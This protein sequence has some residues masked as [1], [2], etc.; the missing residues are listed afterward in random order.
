MAGM[1]RAAIALAVLWGALATAGGPSPCE[2]GPDD[3]EPAAPLPYGIRDVMITDAALP[4]GWKKLP[5]GPLSADAKAVREAI[6]ASGVGRKVEIVERS[7]S[8]ADGSTVCVLFVQVGQEAAAV[9]KAASDA[10]ASPGR[11]YLELGDASRFAVVTGPDAARKAFVDT[12]TAHAVRFLVK[13]ASAP[14]SGDDAT[15]L[16]AAAAAIDPLDAPSRAIVG[17]RRHGEYRTASGTDNA[18]EADREVGRAAE[19]AIAAIP[20]LRAA[21][22]PDVRKPLE[23]ERALEVKVALG[24]ALLSLGGSDREAREVLE[25]ASVEAAA[26]PLE[27]SVAAGFHL[28]RSLARLKNPGVLACLET[29]LSQAA[30]AEGRTI[31]DAWDDE[32]DFSTL[33]SDPRWVALEQ[34]Y[35][36]GGRAFPGR[37][38]RRTLQEGKDPAAKAKDRSWLAAKG[39]APDAE[40]A[41]MAAL[42]WLQAHQGSDGG[43][44]VTEFGRWCD[45]QER[46]ASPEGVGNFAYDVGVSALALLAFL[47]AGYTD[48]DDDPQG[49]R[50]CVAAGFAYL[51]RL[52]DKEGCVG[53]RL[54][55][56]YVYNHAAAAL[57]LVE[58]YGMAPSRRNRLPAQKALD[59]IA[60]ARNP[61][62]AWRYGVKPGDNDTSVTTWM[63]LVLWSA[64][65]IN[66]AEA[67]AGRREPLVYDSDA[68]E[69][70]KSWVDKMTDPDTG[71]VGYLTRGSGSGRVQGLEG[72]FPVERVEASTAEGLCLRLV[73][74]QGA[75]QPEIV[76]G[77][78][79]LAK[80]PPRW[81]EADGSIDFCYWYF[82]TIAL[83]EIG[84]PA[85]TNWRRALLAA[86]LPHQRSDGDPC[87]MLGSWNPSDAWGG[88]GGRVYATAILALALEHPYRYTGD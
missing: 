19:A 26:G 46:A 85:W 41:V 63:T 64:R 30:K 72:R 79:R 28:A 78:G 39:A 59:I 60:I 15:T 55:K 37:I 75:K 17:L 58:R 52:Q 47:G 29:V 83:R 2:G 14:G 18:K 24:N 51:E 34:K 1:R 66:R 69:G 76:M 77:V 8:A 54:I 57:A 25:K 9:A 4:S 38:R 68:W 32:P 42:R 49:F 6:R 22:S 86:V 65:R 13:R 35:V 20:H 67:K 10:S 40:D 23:R 3:P 44:S 84:G 45:G 16:A 88:E 74:G 11:K 12:Q 82:G 62:F 21:L 61:Y 80:L 36:V 56:H 50:R 33:R 31:T 73:C 7:W 5:P 27:L 81:D 87:G 48:H 43:W 71:N 53:E 70:V